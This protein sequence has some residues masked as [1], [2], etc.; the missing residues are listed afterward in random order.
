MHCI[1]GM[2]MSPRSRGAR[3]LGF[4]K[5]LEFVPV[6]ARR[7]AATRGQSE[8]HI[9]KRTDSGD[10]GALVTPALVVEAESQQGNN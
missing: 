2:Q 5:C 4:R 3:R 9:D 7:S 1:V 10:F 8:S 6:V